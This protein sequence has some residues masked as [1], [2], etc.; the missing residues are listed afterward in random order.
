[1][2]NW[3]DGE[4]S[5]RKVLPLDGIVPELGPDDRKTISA[6]VRARIPSFTEEWTNLRPSD[7]GVA[8]IR[9]FGEMTEPVAHRLNR[10]PE[11]AFG[12]FLNIAGVQPLPATAAEVMLEFKASTSAPQSVLVSQGF[13]VGAPPVGAGDL[14]IFE[15]ARTIYVAPADVAAVHVQAEDVFT[16]VKDGAS[17]SVFGQVARAG[18]ALHIGLSGDVPP[19]PTIALGFWLAEG[20]APAPFAS[21][22]LTSMPDGPSALLE[23]H[24]LDGDTYVRCQVVLDETAGLTRSGIVELQLPGGW[25]SGVP[26]GIQGDPL[27]W[28]RVRIAFGAYLKTPALS[29]IRPNIVRAAAARTFRNEALEFVPNSRGRRM[30]LSHFPMLPGSLILGVDEGMEEPD[31][32]QTAD[33]NESPN[34][35]RWTEVDDL[36]SYGPDARVYS[37]DH[38]IGEVTFGDGIHGAIVPPGFRNVIAISYRVGGGSSGAAPADTV[39]TLLTPMPF[40]ESASNPFGASGATDTETLADALL[41]GPLEIRA[42]GRAVA[43]ADY[44]LMA[45]R[46]QGANVKRAHAMAGLHPSYPG[47]P[48]PGV[49]GILVVPAASKAGPPIPDEQT[50]RAV[51]VYLTEHLAPAGVE[52]VAAAPHYHNVKIELGIVIDPA[53]D[54]SGVVRRVLKELDCYLHPLTG[55]EDGRGWPFGGSLQFIAFVRRLF[56]VIPEVRAVPRLNFVLD[57]LRIPQCQDSAIRPHA[58]V[59]PG[60]H[61]VFIAESEEAS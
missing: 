33:T 51:S 61:Q 41:R 2:T 44:E 29:L 43:L 19:G 27:R 59:W 5:G 8:L 7:P 1:M 34:L 28:L 39:K 50:V 32:R 38:A 45:L 30:Q 52:V 31:I 35:M 15:T 25:K 13:Q 14:V 57:G 55:G 18:N 17:F 47:S 26:P 42:R 3:W 49:V 58:L 36:S 48:I 20:L 56:Q 16:Q 10:L 12:E 37:V 40:L 22:G 54:K 53:A 11:K 24:A 21:G 6:A 4:P 23:W 46:A 60:T 9:M